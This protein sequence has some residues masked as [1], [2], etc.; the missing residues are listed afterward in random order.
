[1]NSLDR[2]LVAIDLKGAN[3]SAMRRWLRMHIAERAESTTQGKRTQSLAFARHC[4][5]LG[6]K[7]QAKRVLIGLHGA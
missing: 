5:L 6:D 4:R 1:M 7:H 3:R 2:Y